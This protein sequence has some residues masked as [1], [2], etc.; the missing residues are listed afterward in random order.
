MWR[1]RYIFAYLPADFPE[2]P[3]VLI[4]TPDEFGSSR[5]LTREDLGQLLAS[6]MPE[7]KDMLVAGDFLVVRLERMFGLLEA[8]GKHVQLSEI[9]WW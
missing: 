4:L 6:I 7:G 5:P 2:T 1:E 8:V 3:E 9:P